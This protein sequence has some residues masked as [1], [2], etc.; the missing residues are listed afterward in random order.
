MGLVMR[1]TF[2]AFHQRPLIS[3][4]RDYDKLAVNLLTSG[5]Y[6]YDHQPTAYRPIGYPLFLSLGYSVAGHR[7][8]LIKIIQAIF[9]ILTAFMLYHLLVV[10]GERTQ[11]WGAGLWAFFIPAILYTNFLLSETIF[12]CLLTGSVILIQRVSFEKNWPAVLLGIVFGFLIL[13]KPAMMLF[14]IAFPWFM[15]KTWISLRR[16][17]LIAIGALLVLGPWLVRNYFVL[18]RITLATN[19]GINLLVGN[20]PNATGAY[21][22][23]FPEEILSSARNELEADGFAYRYAISYITQQPLQFGLNAFKK[24]AHLFSSE[25]GLLVWSFH[26]NPEDLT[27]RYATKYASV[28]L[29]LTLLVNLSYF[30]ILIT[31]TAGFIVAQKEKFRWFFG[32]LLLCWLFIHATFFGG[33]RFHFPLMPFFTAFA[34]ILVSRFSEI[35]VYLQTKEKILFTVIMIAYCFIWISELF[36]ISHA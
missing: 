1:L 28:S 3:D 16:Y 22:S 27:I 17:K 36:F 19:G 4:E 15:Y 13:L 20:N 7:P 5:T 29:P 9:D 25:G 21:N 6:G 8:I 34:A 10:Y 33:S 30:F 18:G 31:G 26:A 32:L 24:M 35:I 2:I 14:L 12:T 23:N 11:L